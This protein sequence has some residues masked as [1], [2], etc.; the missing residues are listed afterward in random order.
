MDSF[1][2]SGVHPPLPSDTHSA[3]H[4]QQLMGL[5]RSLEKD[6]DD[7]DVLE[8]A[9]DTLQMLISVTHRRGLLQGDNAV[10][11]AVLASGNHNAA[12]KSL[13]S[14][15]TRR[16]K[17]QRGGSAMADLVFHTNANADSRARPGPTL[18]GQLTM[19]AILRILSSQRKPSAMEEEKTTSNDLNDNLLLKALAADLCTAICGYIMSR[20]SPDTCTIAEYELVALSGKQILGNL[21]DSARSILLHQMISPCTADGRRTVSSSDDYYDDEQI[22]A[23]TACLR[24]CCALCA[25]FGTKLSRSTKLRHGLLRLGWE[26]LAVSNNNDENV[27]Q[28]AATLVATLPLAGGTDNCSP[29]D[30]WNQSLREVVAATRQA[31]HTVAPVTSI[32]AEDFSFQETALRGPVKDT[33]EQ[34]IEGIRRSTSE[35]GRGASFLHLMRSLV[36]VITSLVSRESFGTTGTVP[37]LQ[38]QVDCESMLVLIELML[39][40]PLAA[41]A[42][43]HGTKKR[44]LSE[45]VDGGLISASV[46]AGKVA[47]QVKLYGYKLLDCFLSSLGGSVLLPYARR[48]LRMSHA[49]LLTSSSAAVRSVVD[50]AS[51]SQFSG[52]RQR[53]LHSAVKVRTAAVRAFQSCVLAFGT[54]PDM[55]SNARMGGSSCGCRE[56]VEKSINLICG[57][58]L[59]E[60]SV[61]KTLQQQSEEWG[62]VYERAELAVASADCLADSLAS[63]GEYLSLMIRNLLDSVAVICL[64]SICTGRSGTISF[65]EVKASFLRFATSCVAT[66]WQDGAA[67][68][69]AKDLLEAAR[70]CDKD[71]EYTVMQASSSAIRLCNALACPRAPALIVV[72]RSEKAVEQPAAEMLNQIAV[73]QSDLDNHHDARKTEAETAATRSTKPSRDL[74][75]PSDDRNKRLK[76]SEVE[77]PSI[78]TDGAAQRSEDVPAAAPP[79]QQ[80]KWRKA[81]FEIEP[82]DAEQTLVEAQEQKEADD[83]DD[84]FP[85]IV[86]GEPDDVDM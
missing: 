67:S 43:F 7:L 25:L 38:A 18:D 84:D 56:H 37:L 20:N 54:D 3:Q 63:G 16:G 15:K 52:K 60:V 23:L 51:Q 24:C 22:N 35:T 72:T 26:C 61:E 4:G 86:D 75:Q 10:A 76:I 71:A 2:L 55:Q 46:L 1:A 42:T 27:V 85:M 81:S 11:E 50:P 32:M 53:W 74:A 66:P 5:L 47:N 70:L 80:P 83:S 48:I 34:H 64:S 69:I 31:I 36:A 30:L 41:E 17:Q 59:E 62:S 21:E 39:S 40:F 57:Y 8:Q 49:A 68:S 28:L 65:A 45:L 77:K 29:A 73:A 79:T 14:S 19:L 9:I 13:S 12:A 44:L 82:K 58:L 6:P 78:H 33:L